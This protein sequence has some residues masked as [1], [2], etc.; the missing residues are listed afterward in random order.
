MSVIKGNIK[1]YGYDLQSNIENR[2][3]LKNISI[4][5]ELCISTF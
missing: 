4:F 5:I 3:L 1:R 2:I